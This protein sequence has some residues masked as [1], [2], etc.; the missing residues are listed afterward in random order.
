MKST[1]STAL[2]QK[3][4]PIV[5]VR[6]Q[7]PAP[8]KRSR[9][10]PSE[11]IKQ[12]QHK[13]VKRR[14]QIVH[15]TDADKLNQQSHHV[16]TQKNKTGTASY[17]RRD[18]YSILEERLIRSIQITEALE[19]MVDRNITIAYQKQTLRVPIIAFTKIGSKVNFVDDFKRLNDEYDILVTKNASVINKKQLSLDL[20]HNDEQYRTVVSVLLYL[21]SLNP[22]LTYVISRTPF[23]FTPKVP[24]LFIDDD[25]NA[26]IT[27]VTTSTTTTTTI[28]TRHKNQSMSS[29]T[30]MP[31]FVERL[32]LNCVRITEPGFYY[33]IYVDLSLTNPEPI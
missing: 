3:T 32:Y 21:E 31:S 10:Q 29:N 26:V 20:F 8:Q 9:Q 6:A 11:R 22:P 24:D 13:E 27:T 7:T 28:K 12:Q 5:Q 19:S 4:V 25:S 1:E 14:I 17:F 33:H 15:A 18:E 30:P 23:E 16:R 2:L